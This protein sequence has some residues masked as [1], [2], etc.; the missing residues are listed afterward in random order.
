MS[1]SDFH[2]FGPERSEAAEDFADQDAEAP[3][4][5]LVS[6][7]CA[8][9]HFWRCVCRR[10]AVRS[11]LLV[12][13]IGQ[14]LAKAEVDELD[15][16]APVEQNVFGLQVSVDNVAIV[17]LLNGD[18]YL[19]KIKDRIAH[20]QAHLLSDLLEKLASR[21]ILKEQV[22]ILVVLERLNEVDKEAEAIVDT[23][24]PADS[25]LHLLRLGG[26]RPQDI[27][28]VVH[29]LDVL[30]ATDTFLA[31]LLHREELVRRT[32]PHQRH[33][34]EA[35][36]AQDSDVLELV[37]REHLV[38]EDL[39][40]FRLLLRR[41]RLLALRFSCLPSNGRLLR[42]FRIVETRCRFHHLQHANRQRFLLLAMVLMQ[43]RG[44]RLRRSELPPVLVELLGKGDSI[45]RRLVHRT[46]VLR[47]VVVVFQRRGRPTLFVRR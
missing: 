10:S 45:K 18:E 24:V 27:L 46:H 14:L 39:N 20:G 6:V 7:A 13:K 1:D 42:A 36:P 2:S 34:S 11:G 19:G 37:Q 3:Q 25:L 8:D 35:T 21:E 33:V 40:R 43:V 44:R 38:A 12:F 23:S 26:D 28:L 30:R 17:K 22:Q 29:V 5:R 9:Q 31:D 16:T 47:R 41:L 15:M 32:V 4:V